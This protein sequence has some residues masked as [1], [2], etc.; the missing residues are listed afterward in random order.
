MKQYDKR[1]VH[2]YSYS[3]MIYVHS[4]SRITPCSQ[5]PSIHFTTL[6]DTSLR[7]HL[8]LP[9][10]TSLPSRLD[11]SPFEFSTTSFH[12]T[13]PHFTLLHCTFKPFSSHFYYLHFTPFIIVFLNFFVKTLGSH[14]KVPNASAGSWFLILM[15]LMVLMVL[16][17]SRYGSQHAAPY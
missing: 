6:I 5:R 12:F 7:F 8:A 4:N 9:H 13:S 3:C 16:F 2:I 15:V 17:T 1:N 14:E 11:L 10:F